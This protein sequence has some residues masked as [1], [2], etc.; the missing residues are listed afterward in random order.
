[1]SGDYS[2][3]SPNLDFISLPDPRRGKIC[4][5]LTRDSDHL[6]YRFFSLLRY[7]VH[8]LDIL[9]K[10]NCVDFDICVWKIDTISSLVPLSKFFN[11]ILYLDMQ[12]DGTR[13]NDVDYDA[14][15][16]VKKSWLEL[17]AQTY[18][19]SNDDK[20]FFQIFEAWKSFFLS[21]HSQS[22]IKS[23]RHALMAEMSTTIQTLNTR[24]ELLI[25]EKNS[26]HGRVSLFSERADEVGDFLQR[27]LRVYLHSC[28][29][30][31][32]QSR[33]S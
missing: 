2:K 7:H 24:L 8:S 13:A 11:S 20:I 27:R 32:F 26:F 31:F 25:V 17:L 15:C 23:G 5:D 29:H 10:R 16:Y 6:A 21:S 14:L 19:S 12:G 4:L 1:L 33:V 22:D 30:Y 28:C 18:L 3:N 9:A